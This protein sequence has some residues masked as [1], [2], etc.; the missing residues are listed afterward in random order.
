MI[1]A[2][3]KIGV[4]VSKLDT[5]HHAEALV[6][7]I[8]FDEESRIALFNLSLKN[9]QVEINIYPVTQETCSKYFFIGNEKGNRRQWVLTTNNLEY[10]VSQSLPT[11]ISKMGDSELRNILKQSLHMF[12]YDFGKQG[13][14]ERY[15]YVLNVEKYFNLSSMNQYYEDVKKDVKKVV[16]KV[17][18][19]LKRYI[20]KRYE[21]KQDDIKLWA[22]TINGEIIQQREGY[23]KLAWELKEA[24]FQKATEGVCSVCNSKTKVSSNTSNFRIKYY[25]TQKTNFASNLE[26][27]NKN[28]KLCKECHK[29]IVL[30]EMYILRSFNT[31]LRN[32]KL[33]IIPELLFEEESINPIINDIQK[34]YQKALSIIK[35]EDFISVERDLIKQ[36]REEK[37]ANQYTFNFVFY[38]TITQNQEFRVLQ[39]IK[40]VTL[41]RIYQ[42]NYEIGKQDS[43]RKEWFYWKRFDDRWK[44]TFEQI[45]N[46][47]TIPKKDSYITDVKK[48]LAL[49]EAILTEKTVDKNMIVENLNKLAK[50]CYLG[51]INQYQLDRFNSKE[52]IMVYSILKGNILLKYLENLSIIIGGESM[53]TSQLLL[54]ENLKEFIEDIGY[55]EQQTSL[56]I[57]G[58]LIYEIGKV[59]E[60][61]KLVSKPILNKI[62][63]E[64]MSLKNVQNLSNEVF[65]KLKQYDLITTDKYKDY[66]QNIYSEHK[67]LLDKNI[68]RWKL[69][70]QENVFYILSGYAIGNKLQKRQ[71]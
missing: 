39:L 15:R 40:D 33:L 37:Y 67:I 31:S 6:E 62:N 46:L 44:I 4:P 35:I 42:I 20:S 71:R 16:K 66:I 13:K 48:I 47:L 2:I 34:N 25:I 50:A 32:L 14:N 53:D 70:N 59:Q 12:Y 7:S 28:L 61:A 26:D 55:N 5:R 10:I 52:E 49:Y 11:L 43:F 29:Q 68:N 18:N 17:S 45:Y 27:F 36:L 58:K 24:H 69:S 19:Q 3:R 65:E 56:I 30:G 9:Q 38:I 23:R 21:V 41:T 51:E 63:Y 22:L 57:L 64:G 60:K 8:E 54:D 1:E